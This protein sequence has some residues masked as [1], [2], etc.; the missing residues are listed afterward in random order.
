MTFSQ[1]GKNA[2]LDDVIKANSKEPRRSSRILHG[3]LMTSS[4]RPEYARGVEGRSMTLPQNS[5]LV[6][7]DEPSLRKTLHTSLSVSGFAVEEARNGEEA[8]RTVQRHPFDLVLM[9]VNM[10]GMGGIDAC[11]RIRAMSPHAGIV[12]VTVR[13]LEEDQVRALDAGA[14]DY[15][16]K[17]FRFPE[18]VARLRAVLRRRT[19]YQE[20]PKSEVLQASNLKIDFQKR[21]VWRG[22]EEVRLTPTEFDLLAFMMKHAGTP[23]THVKLLRSVLWGP[24]YSHEAEYLRVYIYRLRKKIENDP[25]KPEYILTEPSVGYRFRNPSDPDSPPFQRDTGSL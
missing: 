23:L 4:A 6:V 2:S 18:L 8:L 11:R 21:L 5:V 19:R 17:P 12:M 3:F 14:D 22:E 20:G 9:D 24:E 13:D 10:P 15:V 16:T 1:P 7:D 25:A